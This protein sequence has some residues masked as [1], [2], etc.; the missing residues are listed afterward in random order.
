MSTLP[1]LN[2]ISTAA[3]QGV[4]KQALED[5]L[6]GVKQLPGSGIAE[7]TLTLASDAVTP[8][9]GSGGIFTIDT[10]AAAAS[11]NLATIAL[12]NFPDG[13]CLIIRPASSARLVVV[14]H[15][16]GGSGQILLRTSGDFTLGDTTH[17]LCLKRTGTSWQEQWRMPALLWWAVDTK[18]GTY[19]VLAADRGKIIDATNGTWTLTFLAVATAGIGFHLSIRNSG[20]GVITLDGNASETIDGATTLKL[21]PGHEII[22]VCDGAGWKSTSRHAPL[23]PQGHRFGCTL[24]NGTNATND[25]DVAAGN[26]ASDDATDTARVLLNAGAM[27]KQL[28]AVWAAGSA[29][30]GRISGEGLAN[31]TWYVYLFRRSGGVDDY[32]F[33]QS[34]SPTLPDSGTH[35]RRIG[36]VLRESAAIVGFVQDGDLFTRKAAVLDVNATNPGTAAVTRTLSVPTGIPVLARL[37]LYITGTNGSQW[38]ELL[39]DLAVTD[40]APSLTAAPLVTVRGLVDSAAGAGAVQVDVRTNTSGQIRSRSVASDASYIVRIATLGWIDSLGRDN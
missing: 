17:W 1:A 12:T 37:N 28:D 30:G 21:N 7:T 8:P 27:T 40:V 22:L 20:T 3:N 29:A 5:F 4:L 14:K 36:S 32:C 38:G 31:G 10:E 2:A 19:T 23:I 35:K 24:A 11:D 13:S 9:G 39:T 16:G 25:I 26:W 6:A 33:S 18:T 15:A 34:L